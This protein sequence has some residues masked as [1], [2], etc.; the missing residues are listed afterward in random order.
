[1][2]DLTNPNFQQHTG[3]ATAWQ[4]EHEPR[5]VDSDVE[6]RVDNSHENCHSWPDP[7]RSLL[8]DRRGSLPEFPIDTLSTDWRRWLQNAARGA[9][10]LPDHVFMPLLTLASTL[11]GASRPIR[12]SRSWSEVMALWTCVVGFS[13]TGKTPGLNVTM[14]ALD[15]IE[16]SRKGKIAELRGAHNSRA[17]TAKAAAKKWRK[18]VAAAVEDGRKGPEMPPEARDPGEFIVPRLAVT[19]VTI[20]RL[21]VL[22]QA[23]PSGLAVICDELAGLFLNMARYSNGS[24]REFWLRAY[25][26]QSHIVE[27]QGRPAI[28]LDHLLVGLTGGFQPDKLA[29]SFKGD[30]D[31]MYARMLFAWPDEPSYRELSNDVDEVEPEFYNAIA[32]LA[33]L[34]K[35]EDGHLVKHSIHISEEAVA[36]FEQ[37]RKFSHRRREA[38]D[39]RE[40]EWSAKGPG[41]VLRLAGTL[42]WLDWAM[43]G[44]VEEPRQIDTA[45]IDSAIQLW[46]EYFLPH[47]RAALRQIGLTDQHADARGVLRWARAERRSTVSREEIRRDALAQRLD[48]AQTQKLIDALVRAGWLREIGNQKNGRGRPARRWQVNPELGGEA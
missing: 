2:S 10:V 25:N 21:A 15:A 34:A 48:A 29:A 40:R 9:G 42:C 23:R 20:E 30:C 11:V 37:F 24:D 8:D 33:D 5:Q 3:L 47:A 7:D 18:E 44:Q 39:G 35:I 31:G 38:L 45:Y 16:R 27:R 32:R 22:L 26:G 41:Q 28:E 46:R 4:S 43:A 17:E 13:G 1:M 12:A 14:R 6:S 19:D 36:V